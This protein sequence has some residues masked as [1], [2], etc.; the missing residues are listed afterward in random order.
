MAIGAPLAHSRCPPVSGRFHGRGVHVGLEKSDLANQRNRLLLRCRRERSESVIH[1]GA[2]DVVR[3]RDVA[4]D[5]GA[6]GCDLNGRIYVRA[7]AEVRMEVFDLQRH[8]IPRRIFDAAAGDPAGASL[9]IA[10]TG[11]RVANLYGRAG[12][13]GTTGAIKQGTLPRE[14]DAPTHGVEPL[15]FGLARRGRVERS[16]I[17]RAAARVRPRD[18]VLDA[19]HPV[20]NLIIAADCPPDETATEIETV[21]DREAE[22][23]PGRIGSSVLAAAPNSA[24]FHTDVATRP[25]KRHYDGRLVRGRLDRQVS[26]RRRSGQA[27][28]HD[29]H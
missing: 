29:S 20:A 15:L 21:V 8:V 17:E 11:N 22:I 13:G 19:E 14:A 7:G 1:A 4:S 2:H 5:Y 27:D 18:V 10:D 3:Q 25:T 12:E 28:T 24:A 9:R 16:N 23:G 26:R 6:A